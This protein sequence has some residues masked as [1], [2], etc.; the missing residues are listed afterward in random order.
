MNREI[1]YIRRAISSRYYSIEALFQSITSEVS[2]YYAVKFHQVPF[3]GA[4]PQ[5]L[6]KNGISFKKS[7]H[8]TKHI[9]GDVHYMALFTGSK[10][11]LTIH[12]IGSSLTGNLIKQLYIKIF[13]YWLPALFVKRITVISDFTKHELKRIIPFAK[14]KI[15]VVPN[16]VNP[17]FKSH[18]FV[19]NTKCP[20]IL[21]VGTKSNKNLE[22]IFEAVSGLSCEL[23]LIGKLSQAQYSCLEKQ[24]IDYRNQVQ[25][26]QDEIVQAY[27]NCDLLCFPSTYEGFGMPII[28][29]QATGRPV[30]TTDFGAMKEVAQDAACLVD[31]YDVCAIRI[32]LEKIIQDEIYRNTLITKGF[33]NVKR[34]QLDTIVQQYLAI[35][36]DLD[37]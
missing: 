19:F 32:G 35:Y 7:N 1:I 30:L 21:C 11:I 26:T 14:H 24:D 6:I 37:C 27:K 9:T 17:A 22:R 16:P 10:T 13:W 5:H 36:K 2:K 3:L 18:P 25:L 4:A 28:E 12:D 34:F 20:V 15:V 8:S 29:A 31:A 33:D 23:H